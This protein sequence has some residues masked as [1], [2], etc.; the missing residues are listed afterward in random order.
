[1]TSDSYAR[2]RCFHPSGRVV[3]FKKEEI[4][5]SIPQRFEKIVREYPDRL[6]IKTKKRSLTYNELNRAANRIA[7]AILAE[8]GAK[9]EPVALLMEHDAPVVAGILGSL[10]A[11][12]FYVPLDPSLPH[13]RIKHILEDL[14][15]NYILTNSG[16]L[17]LAKTLAETAIRLVNSDDLDD[18]P[19]TSLSVDVHPDHLCWV[20][21]TSGS[22][23][24]PKGVIQTHRNVL[25][26]MM[27]YVNGLH[28]CADDR[29]TLLYS[30][31]V[32][33]GSHDIFA[34]LL[35]GAAL[36]PLDLKEEGFAHL[37][38]WLKEERITIYHSV[39]TVFRQFVENL[40]GQEEFQD[41]RIL[42]LG[43]EPVY[44]RELDLFKKHFSKHCILVNRL[45][46]SETGSLRMY[47]VDKETQISGNLVPVGY[48]VMDNEILLLDDAG[49]Q[50]AGDEG[51]I[52]VRTPYVS[53]GYWGR[54]DL[55]ATVFLP[56]PAGGEERMYRTGD[57]G[58]MLPDGCLLHLGRKDFFVK[59]RGYRIDIDEIEM[60]LLECPGIKEAV[61]VARNNNSGDERLVAYVVPTLRPAPDVS[62]LRTFLRAKLPEYMVPWAFVT[63]DA[64]PLTATHKIDRKALPDPSTSRPNI[65]TPYVGPKTPTEQELARIWAEVLSVDQVGIHDDFFALGGHSLAASRVISRVI[66][67]FQLQ[68]PIRALFD[69]PTVAAMADVIADNV[70]Q[71]AS[72]EDLRRLL[73]EI[74]SLSEEEIQRLLS[75]QN[76]P[77]GI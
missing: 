55:T 7:Q 48:A 71:K 64:M 69:S 32:N 76:R 19:D 50:V 29:L 43:G 39:P 24:K 14:P 45:G 54:P 52:A 35:N 4:E 21:Y 44:K 18:F 68:L 3:E 20:I 11:G 37:G 27:N 28:I 16:N 38:D 30:F 42:R 9:Q 23:G 73:G 67:V 34:A 26:F 58:R 47:F 5:Q 6:A 56:D 77:K 57:L 51:E 74:D 40:T 13:A 22:T 75:E 63:L 59:V 65:A 25:H 46:S 60:A 53:P 31:S 8:R 62:E 41:L 49:T 15:A 36:F 70:K 72:E 2:S 12:K 61:V 17:S 1:M 10:K 33:G 66:A